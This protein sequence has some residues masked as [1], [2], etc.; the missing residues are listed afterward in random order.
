RV[1]AMREAQLDAWL[2]PPARIARDGGS[3]GPGC[4]IHHASLGPESVLRVAGSLP[5]GATVNDALLAGL[6]LT[7]DAWNR[8]HGVRSDRIALIVPLNLRPRAWRR[9]VYGNFSVSAVVSTRPHERQNAKA[10]LSSIAEQTREIKRNP[11]AAAIVDAYRLTYFAPA[12][13]K[14]A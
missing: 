5:D 8:G 7:I 13:W 12:F 14:R 3:D 1:R 10:L 11:E 6:S 4:G 2:A 9:D